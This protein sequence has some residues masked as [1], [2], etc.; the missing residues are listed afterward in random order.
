MK[1]P[2][3]VAVDDDHCFAGFD[4]YKNVIERSDA[5]L[6]ANA[7][8]FH[9]LHMKAAIEAG[10]HVFVEKPHAIDPAGHQDG[11][12]RLRVG[13]DEE[14]VRAF[15][16]C[17]AASIRCYRETVQRIHDGA[18]GDIVAIQEN[19]LR[20]PY[21]LYP[22]KPGLTEVEYQASNQYHFH[23]L[24]G[25]DVPQSL[26]HNLDRAG[27]VMREQA[28]VKCHGMGGRS[29]LRGEIYGNVFD[30]HAVV[31]EYRERR[32]AVRLLPHH[33]GLLQREL[34]RHAGHQGALQPD[35]AASRARPNG[36]TAGRS[37][38]RPRRSILPDRADRVRAS[39]FASGKPINSADYMTRSTLIGIMGQLSCYSGKEVT[40]EQASASDFY[41]RPEARRRAR[42]HGPAGEAGRGRQLSGGVHA[43]SVEAPMKPLA[44]M[45]VAGGVLLGRS[46][47]CATE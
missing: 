7:A 11:E 46:P 19:F 38:T 10:K 39:R 29:T 22:R 2:D 23:W 1:F 30:H 25:D 18:I 28:P 21:G 5:V 36:N 35:A 4:A 12:G 14:P 47:I 41:Y 37:Y 8:K 31:Y 40:W 34:Q 26:I 15:R 20:A 44:A 13:Q 16:A 45:I 43:G 33:P 32:A 17:R 42:G 24:S 3:Q 9:P 6:I 27:W